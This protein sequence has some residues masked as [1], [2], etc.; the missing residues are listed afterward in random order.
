MRSGPLVF[1][2]GMYIFFYE[3]SWSRV[4]NCDCMIACTSALQHENSVGIAAGST[5]PGHLW[6]FPFS[7]MCHRKINSGGVAGWWWVQRHGHGSDGRLGEQCAMEAGAFA[8][9]AG[10]WSPA[11]LER[12]RE[13]AAETAR[14]AQRAVPNLRDGT[15]SSNR[16][17]ALVKSSLPFW[18]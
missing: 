12:E 3:S 8:R 6:P 7:R 4:C 5:S 16:E 17:A 15:G 10:R 9:Q 14:R 18:A 1:K 13:G 11:E 2:V